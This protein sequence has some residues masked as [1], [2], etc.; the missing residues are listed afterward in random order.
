MANPT[1]L[2]SLHSIANNAYP[3][4]RPGPA[5]ERTPSISNAVQKRAQTQPKGISL[6]LVPAVKKRCTPEAQKILDLAREVG[7]LVGTASTPLS[8]PSPARNGLPTTAQIE[9]P[10]PPKH[11]Y[12]TEAVKSA[13]ISAEP[14]KESV[15]VT[16]RVEVLPDKGRDTNA[17][18]TGANA[19]VSSPLK[20]RDLE[21]SDAVFG[22]P[23]TY[24]GCGVTS[25]KGLGAVGEHGDV[26]GNVP[27]AAFI[28]QRVNHCE[29]SEEGICNDNKQPRGASV[30]TNESGATQE[31][32]FFY[33]SHDLSDET[34]NMKS[35][36]VTRGAVVAT[37][38][39]L[40]SARETSFRKELIRR[41]EHYS[42]GGTEKGDIGDEGEWNLPHNLGFV[43]QDDHKVLPQTA[44]RRVGIPEPCRGV[45]SRSG[46]SPVHV[47]VAR[48][49]FMASTRP[50]GVHPSSESRKI[51]N[52]GRA[53]VKTTK[54][55]AP[56]CLSDIKQRNRSK[57]ATTGG[58]FFAAQ[59]AF[60]SFARPAAHWLVTKSIG[61]SPCQADGTG[62]RIPGVSSGGVVGRF[63]CRGYLL[64]PI[65]TDDNPVILHPRLQQIPSGGGFSQEL[66]GST[67]AELVAPQEAKG[68]TRGNAGVEP[69][70]NVTEVLRHC[71]GVSGS[72]K[73]GK[74]R[75]FDEQGRPLSPVNFHHVYGSLEKRRRDHSEPCLIPFP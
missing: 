7:Y 10:S 42:L 5:D 60:V 38:L 65:F 23:G 16:K 57:G 70:R 73:A 44:E 29:N 26:A 75:F 54:L 22:R 15:D 40:L 66:E 52:K 48:S 71:V 62:V 20:V 61:G 43:M 47:D 11:D 21:R 14:S 49:P 51:L 13:R 3:G 50:T 8:S 35:N 30:S 46:V 25:C 36:S 34:K 27:H 33:S 12:V 17:E 19:E 4:Y 69:Y 63:A 58:A 56:S 74:Q 24:F 28:L 6:P 67:L 37:P 2:Q 18:T 64:D 59:K 45:R 31:S 53:G 72:R 39:A 55:P 41:K 1:L 9:V 32:S 68:G